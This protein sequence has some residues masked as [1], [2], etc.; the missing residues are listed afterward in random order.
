MRVEEQH[1]W[2]NKSR[3]WEAMLAKAVIAVQF[4]PQRYLFDRKRSS[5][6]WI[7]NVRTNLAI[8]SPESVCLLGFVVGLFRFVLNRLPRRHQS[9]RGFGGKISR[10]RCTMDASISRGV[11][12]QQTLSAM[13]RGHLRKV[14]GPPDG[15]G[16]ESVVGN[17]GFYRA[18]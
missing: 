17:H 5:S 11:R 2:A 13:S 6:E 3:F 9:R 4:V 16:D 10:V 1:L 14:S 18:P 7:I 8:P 15:A 12:R